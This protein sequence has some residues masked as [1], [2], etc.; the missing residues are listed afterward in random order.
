MFV[1]WRSPPLSSAPISG[2]FPELLRASDLNL[3]A[4][5]DGVPV[6][7]AVAATLESISPQSS[8]RAKRIPALNNGSLR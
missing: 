1:V 8:L 4:R 5:V 3:G 7:C 2:M 6:A